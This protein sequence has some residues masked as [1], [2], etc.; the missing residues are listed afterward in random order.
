MK[1]ILLIHTVLQNAFV[2]ISENDKII[3]LTENDNQKEHGAFLHEAIQSVLKVNTM[4]PSGIDAIA[5]TN[6]P[7]SYTGIRVGLSAAKGLAYSLKKPV[8]VCSTLKILAGTGVRLLRERASYITMI[9]ARKEE[10]FAGFYD[11]TLKELFPEG[12]FDLKKGLP[13]VSGKKYF[14]GPDIDK[15]ILK[16]KGF[17]WVD[18]KQLNPE[19]MAAIAFDK[20]N[21]NSFVSAESVVPNYLKETYTTQPHKKE[22]TF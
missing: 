19:A 10:Y 2:A 7:G 1:K 12:L 4:N 5:V 17:Q 21:T 15:D 8:L 6:G 14:F 18:V 11:E 20:F 16:D 9:H 3:T 22:E 13:E